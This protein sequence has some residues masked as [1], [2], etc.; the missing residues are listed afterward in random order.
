MG[1]V[2][3]EIIKMV[4]PEENE[5][6]IQRVLSNFDFRRV[7]YIMD[8]L[9]WQW[10]NSNSGGEIPDIS[11]IKSKARNLLQEAINKRY[12]SNSHHNVPYEVS[13]GGLKA[14]AYISDDCGGIYSLKLEFVPTEF[15]I[16]NPKY[17]N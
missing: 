17:F 13:E 8:K 7:K 4:T 16:F 6:L 15:E 14:I 2:E 5:L 12:K 3:K 1:N 10:F 11:S 9:Q